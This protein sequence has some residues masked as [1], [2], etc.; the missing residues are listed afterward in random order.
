M[1]LLH[2]TPPLNIG[3]AHTSAL[4]M[5]TNLIYFHGG[6]VIKDNDYLSGKS[7]PSVFDYAEQF[8][9]ADAASILIGGIGST[10]LYT[11][12]ISSSM[13]AFDL[14]TFEWKKL[15][16]S[17]HSCYAHSL[18]FVAPNK[19]VFY[20]GICDLNRFSY[21]S[22]V[23]V[24][25]QIRVYDTSRQEWSNTF[26]LSNSEADNNIT[27]SHFSIKLERRQRYGH[28]SFVFNKHLYFFA[29]F[30][31]FFLRD[32][33][34]IEIDRMGF[35]SSEISNDENSL[36]ENDA[37][38]RLFRDISADNRTYAETLLSKTNKK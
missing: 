10:H 28:A 13:Y 22:T 4:D 16:R 33:F 36:Y 35:A 3:F 17:T 23:H 1:W 25:N 34:R 26:S 14:S 38:R 32:F 31:G 6:L 24:S 30:N 27:S 9:L 19:L 2:N 5:T 12:S 15:P 29:G 8:N 20:G 37:S 21:A 18:T 11:Q 7:S